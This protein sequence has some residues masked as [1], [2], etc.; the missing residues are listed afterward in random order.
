MFG[1]IRSVCIA[2]AFLA[3][4]C[5]DL[6]GQ[7]GGTSALPS[8]AGTN[9][10]LRVLDWNAT[11][12]PLPATLTFPGD[13]RIAG[14]ATCNTYT[15]TVDQEA[16]GRTKRSPLSLSGRSCFER[17]TLQ[18]RAFVRALASAYRFRWEGDVLYMDVTYSHLP[19][20]FSR[21]MADLK[22]TVTP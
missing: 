10:Q 20:K 11:L 18:E 16:G 12:D 3:A 5:A 17:P 4:G 9:W 7:P 21:V 13:G 6:P 2:T 8:L 19:V 15:G 14:N 22:T 1:H